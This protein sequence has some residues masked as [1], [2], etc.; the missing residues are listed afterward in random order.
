MSYPTIAGHD[1]VAEV[2]GLI[3]TQTNPYRFPNRDV[4]LV[5]IAESN[6]SVTN[7]DDFID[8]KLNI[9]VEIG[10]SNRALLETSLDTLYGICAGHDIE[11]ILPYAGS[12]RLWYGSLDNVA[13][14]DVL[15]GH[16]TFE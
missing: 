15:G 7:G 14:T 4:N 2:P 11:L 12:T 8:K 16:G 6:K 1:I 13:D 3:I 9:K 5:R 10:R